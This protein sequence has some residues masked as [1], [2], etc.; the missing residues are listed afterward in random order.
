MRRIIALSLISSLAVLLSVVPSQADERL[1]SLKSIYSGE[2]D[3][4]VAQ[5]ASDMADVNKAYLNY[6]DAALNKAKNTG[7]LDAYGKVN[8]ER[9]RFEQEKTIPDESPV[10]DLVAKADYNK[11]A[12]TL[13][14]AKK[15]VAGLNAHKIALMKSDNIKGAK[16][17]QTEIARVT[18]EAGDLAS[19]MPA[20]ATPSIATAPVKPPLK[21]AGS[22]QLPLAVRKDLVLWYGFDKD[23]KAHVT[24]KSG[25]GNDGKAKD[26]TWKLLS[27]RRRGVLESHKAI[28]VPSVA[29]GAQWS[30][31]CW[32]QFPLRAPATGWRT[33]LFSRGGNHHA[34]VSKGGQLGCYVGRF[35]DSGFSVKK[36]KGWHHMAGIALD[37]KT[38]FYIDGKKV[39]TSA[40]ACTPPVTVVG[41][42]NIAHA[43]QDWA[44]PLDELMI[45]NRALS[46]AEVKQVYKATGGK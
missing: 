19:K 12:A 8:K 2:M 16:E 26:A 11:N 44:V 27:D 43:P 40:M 10:K 46:E 13:D 36:L 38:V 18:F 34:L 32:T 9:K 23:E 31:A 24:D 5:W 15:Y 17:V 4:I 28:S 3:R 41:N 14:L 37:G 42:T 6:L 25:A 35:W 45:W 30:F 7:D 29:M 33:L 1:D 21:T 20:K 39:G 22:S